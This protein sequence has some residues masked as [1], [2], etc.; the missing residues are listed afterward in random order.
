MSTVDSEIE[1]F[2]CTA[3]ERFAQDSDFRSRVTLAGDMAQ[4]IDVL[5]GRDRGLNYSLHYRM[6]AG[7]ALL[8]AEEAS[9]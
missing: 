4:R 1:H 8:L 9:A 2:H 6:A 7:I 3:V 5:L